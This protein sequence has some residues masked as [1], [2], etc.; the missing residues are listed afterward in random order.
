VRLHGRDLAA[1]ERAVDDPVARLRYE[2]RR[3]DL[4]PWVPRIERLAAGGRAVHVI[5]TVAPREGASRAASL[6]VKVLTDPPGAAPE[7]PP[8]P[9]PRRRRR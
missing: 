6:L 9:R 1:W 4:E 2:Y 3:A 5:A 7:P 8:E